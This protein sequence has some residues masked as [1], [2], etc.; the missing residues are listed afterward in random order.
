LREECR[1]KEFE[2]RGLRKIYGPK[3]EEIKENWRKLRSGELHD[4]Y[5]SHRM[6]LRGQYD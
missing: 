3:Y 4:K 5:S 1:L 6:Q 2:K